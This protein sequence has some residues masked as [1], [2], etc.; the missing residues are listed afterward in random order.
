MKIY[1]V[2]LGGEEKTC[3]CP[4]KFWLMLSLNQKMIFVFVKI[5]NKAKHTKAF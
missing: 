5:I 1:P 4:C 3:P 2:S